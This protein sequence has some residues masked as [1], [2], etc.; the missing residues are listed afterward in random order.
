VEVEQME[1][2]QMEVE[3]LLSFSPIENYP[4]KGVKFMSIN[5]YYKI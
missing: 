3:R 2:E 1:V 4:L 5:S